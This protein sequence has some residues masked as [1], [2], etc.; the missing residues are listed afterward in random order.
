MKKQTRAQKVADYFTAFKA[1]QENR[2][3]KRPH[4]KDGSIATH[5]V[6]SVP[7]LSEAIVLQDCLKWLK[8]HRI[9]ANR[10]NVGSGQMG[11]SGFYSYGIKNAGDIIGL[12]KRGIH[13]EIEVKRGR[14]G[15]LSV[16]QQK[17]MLM[18]RENN[19]I[20]LVIH[21]IAELEYY[22]WS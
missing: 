7:D 2:P 22:F 19:G 21:G 14:G 12:T 5:S 3:V 15:R 9:V 20:Y 8:Q 6:V 11:E 13:F 16:G 4:A 17:R 1:L 18:I 10:N